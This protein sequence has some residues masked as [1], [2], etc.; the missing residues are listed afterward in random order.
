[1]SYSSIYEFTAAVR[2]F[3][4][5]RKYWT[6]EPEQELHCSHERGN[7]FDRYAIKVCEIGKDIPVGHLP[8]EIS[9]VSKF[10]IDRGATLS[11]KLTGTH[12]RRSPLV[13][14]GLE[15][16][17]KIT[18]QIPGT[19]SNLLVMEK[20]KQLVAELYIEPKEEEVLGSFLEA[21]AEQRGEAEEDH[22]RSK[23]KP[24][25]PPKKTQHESGVR[26]I[27]T[28]FSPVQ[29]ETTKKDKGQK[30]PEVINVD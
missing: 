14:G 12:Y 28:F 8:K 6:P 27:R 23:E 2:G 19:V 20:Y 21:H 3:H 29:R 18:A 11:V 30:K 9:R 16:P 5:Y 17:C 25:K 22:R 1:M 24:P 10:F 13:Q 26:D 7:A 4:H 15:I